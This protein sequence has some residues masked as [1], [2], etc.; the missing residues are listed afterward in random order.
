LTEFERDAIR[1]ALAEDIGTGDATTLS[2][3]QEALEL[4]GVLIARGEGVIAGLDVFEAVFAEAGGGVSVTTAIADGERTRKGDEVARMRGRGRT[5]LSGERTA[6]NFLQRMSGIATMTRA[7]VDAVAGTRAVILD[8]R[9]TAPGL[10]AFDK[11]AVRIGGGTNHRTGLF[12]MVLIK[13]NHIDAAGGIA[14]AVGRVRRGAFS[15]LAIEV[16]CR[17]LDEVDAAVALKVDRIML[18][19]M[20]IETIRRAVAFVDARVPLEVSGGV[21]LSTVRG[22]AD[23]GV[24]FIS[25]GALTH[26]APALDLSLILSRR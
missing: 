24:D 5:L 4:D 7:F 1:R 8:T 6:L 26:S 19:N 9:K 17:T 20:D 23:T 16:E 11:R 10:R 3:I 15:T 13:D 12:D 2:T 25:I 14:V 21:S 22:I 18:D